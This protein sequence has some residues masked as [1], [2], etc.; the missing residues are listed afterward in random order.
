MSVDLD[1]DRQHL[2]HPYTSATNPQP[3]YPVAAASGCWLTLDDGRELLDGMSSWWAAVHGYNHPALNDALTTQLGKMAHVM[4]G[5]ITHEPAVE[6]GKR[7][8]AI[9]PEPLQHCFLADSGSVAMEVAIKMATQ[10]QWQQGKPEKHRF[11]ALRKGY[12]GDTSGTMALCDPDTGMHALFSGILPE[13]LFLPSPVTPFGEALREEDRQALTSAFEQHHAAVAALVLEPIVQGAGGMHFYSAEYLTLA[14]ELCDQYDILLIADEIATGFGRS[15]ELFACNH[16]AIAPDIMAVGKAL[17]GGYM[18]LAAT[19]A[20]ADVANTI[21][22][23][24]GVMMHGPTFMGNPLAC[25]V[26]C[27][28]IDLLLDSPWQARVNAI[29]ARAEA[30]LAPLRANPA[31]ADLRIMGAIAVVELIEPVAMEEITARFVEAGLWVRPF[32]KLVY[33]MPPF[34]MPEEEQALLFSRFKT[35]I[36]EYTA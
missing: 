7:L 6:L 4:F 13:H 5:G 15:G 31:V 35:V 29:A 9:T 14:R 10:Y 8:L 23:D 33:L 27:A 12:H 28:S 17:T 26:A 19:L 21:S 3:V 32:G 24:G 34:I 20:T 36:E 30:T 22:R 1:F 2:W 16:A 11:M 25:A 18:T